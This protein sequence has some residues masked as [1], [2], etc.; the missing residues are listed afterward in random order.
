MTVLLPFSFSP[1]VT[2]VNLIAVSYLRHN[3]HAFIPTSTGILVAHACFLFFC[4]W[5]GY[6]FTSQKLTLSLIRAASSE[7]ETPTL[8]EVTAK[9]EELYQGTPSS[10]GLKDVETLIPAKG[11]VT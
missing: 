5:I 8:E 9:F 10:P 1:R 3:T 6:I 2:Y 11:D 4:G 7:G